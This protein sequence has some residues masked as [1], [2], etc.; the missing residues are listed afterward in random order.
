MLKLTDKKIEND[1]LNFTFKTSLL[2]HGPTFCDKKQ[3]TWVTL[4]TDKNRQEPKRADK[5][6]QESFYIL[7]H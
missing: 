1:I 5:N 3:F 7:I 4:I 2:L 6:R